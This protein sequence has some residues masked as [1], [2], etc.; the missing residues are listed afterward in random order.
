MLETMYILMYIYVMPKPKRYS[1]AEARSSFPT[2]V[3][4]AEAGLEV[5][6]TRRGKPVAVLVSRDRWDRARAHRPRFADLYKD[7]L[8]RYSIDKV[9]LEQES[10]RVPREDDSG[11][12]VNL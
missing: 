9:G 5:E 4:E 11:R 7:F 12:E 2:L 8:G 10:L 1:I 3:R 6:L